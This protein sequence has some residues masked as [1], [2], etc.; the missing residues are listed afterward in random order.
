MGTSQ[1]VSVPYAKYAE[2]AGSVGGSS[3]VET[4]IIGKVYSTVTTCSQSTCDASFINHIAVYSIDSKSANVN[5][6]VLVD[7]YYSA[8]FSM[9]YNPST[10]N[11]QISSIEHPNST[12]AV[13]TG[14]GSVSNN[15]NT[16]TLNFTINDSSGTCICSSILTR[17]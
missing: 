7:N 10:S 16:M 11:I 17:K 1:M 13:G 3:I 9:T 8:M 4:E 14:T 12:S 15:Y 2:T 6:F 5:Y